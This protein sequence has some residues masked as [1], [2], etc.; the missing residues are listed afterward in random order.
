MRKRAKARYVFRTSHFKS[1]L[2]K[3]ELCYGAVPA[4]TPASPPPATPAS[5]PA[6]PPPAA[7][8]STPAPTPAAGGEGMPLNDA[9]RTL[10]RSAIS[11]CLIARTS[12]NNDPI[13]HSKYICLPRPSLCMCTC[14]RVLFRAPMNRYSSPHLIPISTNIG[15]NTASLIKTSHAP[16]LPSTRTLLWRPPCLLSHEKP[17]WL[18]RSFTD[19][20]NV[21]R[22]WAAGRI[23][24]LAVSTS[25]FVNI[26]FFQVNTSLPSGS[27]CPFA[28]HQP[29]PILRLSDSLH[30]RVVRDLAR[31]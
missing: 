15:R 24:S 21:V 7:P 31:L 17:L 5:T 22:N 26:I 10:S 30:P 12:V 27:K 23:V 8:A 19:F 3:T 13:H 11:C 25:S 2:S 4:S 6:S 1:D 18:G 16:Y 9:S 20:H 14:C 29:G 28:R